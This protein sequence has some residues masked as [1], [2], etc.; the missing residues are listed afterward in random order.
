MGA[1]HDQGELL[2][3]AL[4]RL[5]C[6]CGAASFEPFSKAHT[7]LI[8][9]QPYLSEVRF[10]GSVPTPWH[11]W[12]LVAPPSTTSPPSPLLPVLQSFLANLTE[13]IHAFNAPAAREGASK[14]LIKG[15]FGYP[16]E[17]VKAWLAQVDYPHGDVVE[18]SKDMVEKTLSCVSLSLACALVHCRCAR[19]TGLDDRTPLAGRSRRRA[20]SRLPQAGGTSTTLSRRASQGC[21]R[22]SSTRARPQTRRSQSLVGGGGS[23]AR[24]ARIRH[25]SALLLT[26]LPF[27]LVLR[28]LRL[29]PCPIALLRLTFEATEMATHSAATHDAHRRVLGVDSSILPSPQARA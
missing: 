16:E 2:Q 27:L 4:Q 20:C 18:V 19:L 12:V 21:S 29:L 26:A 15:H 11:S 10:I 5:G 7:P 25:S 28:P 14:E 9:P 8:V 1:L 24:L 23:L 6:A 13:S 3:A 22:I 17:D